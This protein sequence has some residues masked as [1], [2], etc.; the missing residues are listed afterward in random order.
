MDFS[1]IKAIRIP[2]GN[3][4]K[5]TSKADGKVLWKAGIDPFILIDFEYTANNDGTY[6]LTG[7]KETLNGEPSNE[8]IIPNNNKIVLD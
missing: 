2:E 6:T 3:V 8:M 5:I 1:T 4:T 7:W